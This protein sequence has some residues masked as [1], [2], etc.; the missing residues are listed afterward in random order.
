MFNPLKNAHY[1]FK[2][3]QLTFFSQDDLISVTADENITQLKILS[4]TLT[5]K[6]LEVTSYS[7]K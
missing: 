7:Q 2:R 6:I 4:I 5:H 1:A 3:E